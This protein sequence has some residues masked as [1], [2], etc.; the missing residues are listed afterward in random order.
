MK[1]RPNA[2]LAGTDGSR[3]PSRIQS[4]AKTG[5]SRITKIGC[6]DWNHDDGNEK[7]RRSRRV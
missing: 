6:T 2:N 3:G 4:Q 7:P 5:A 1:R